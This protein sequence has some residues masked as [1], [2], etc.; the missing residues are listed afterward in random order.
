[1]NEN[2]IAILEEQVRNLTSE[3]N[4][5]KDQ[6]Q[7]VQNKLSISNN[8]TVSDNANINMFTTPI[9]SYANTSPNTTTNAPYEYRQTV[10][11]HVIKTRTTDFENI[12]GKR[13]MGIFAC[14]LIFIA[15]ILLASLILP[16]LNDTAKTILMFIASFSFLIPGLLLMKKSPQNK[17]YIALT[18]CGYGLI[19][20]SLFITY[21]V[22]GFI[23]PYILYAL[24]FIWVGSIYLSKVNNTIFRT[25]AQIGI[26]MSVTLSIFDSNET[27]SFLI[28]SYIIT[29]QILLL[30]YEQIFYKKIYVTEL[31]GGIACLLT[32][33][34]IFYQIDE[35]LVLVAMCIITIYCIYHISCTLQ[36]GTL[37]NMQAGAVQ[38]ILP[39]ILYVYL[40]HI[41]IV[42]SIIRSSWYLDGIL[43]DEVFVRILFQII[44]YVAIGAFMITAL[45]V[46]DRRKIN[47]FIPQ[48]ISYLMYLYITAT[49]K[50]IM[51]WE[52]LYMA[53][54]LALYYVCYYVL[55]IKKLKAVIGSHVV[56]VY[57]VGSFL[58][59][60]CYISPDSA[61]HDALALE[62]YAYL[63]MM[64]I[65]GGVN[66]LF[67][68]RHGNIK[69]ARITSYIINVLI[70]L[71]AYR[72]LTTG[73]MEDLS[74]IGQNEVTLTIFKIIYVVLISAIFTINSKELLDR[75]TICWDFYIGFKYLL[76]IIACL[77]TFDA[78]A[79]IVSIILL[80]MA[81]ICIITGFMNDYKGLRIFG[82]LLAMICVFK[83]IFVD[84][85]ASSTAGKVI[86][87][88]ISGMLCFVINMIYNAVDKKLHSNIPDQ[89]S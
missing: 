76:L 56:L 49:T 69:E 40:L 45:I 5:L 82:L 54:P 4:N 13:L 48:I 29:T 64:L 17:F 58:F 60:M 34:P 31:I 28:I 86:S 74:I 63:L 47:L 42:S 32:F 66:Y 3:V 84:I 27:L 14:V 79:V 1:M 70:M 75:H 11:Q 38:G 19:F 51:I 41:N 7:Y 53:I 78:D 77:H 71:H 65:C 59:R 37:G 80:I 26:F 44:T 22:F 9:S 21:I 61:Y 23:N 52:Y 30:A 72:Y 12:L 20:V 83:L 25:I 85:S 36:C 87:F 81:I 39:I 62:G 6:M 46:E 50:D 43:G 55:N 33:I 24:I 88:F 67:K 68:L 10:P 57:L 15:A 16:N 2:R 35:V 89:K 73:Q 18:G 8:K